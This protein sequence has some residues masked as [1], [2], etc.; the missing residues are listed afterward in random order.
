M[1]DEIKFIAGVLTGGEPHC[2][3]DFDWYYILGFLELHKIAGVFYRR[4]AKKNIKIPTVVLRKLQGIFKGQE[5]RVRMMRKWIEDVSYELDC[6]K[7]DYIFLKGSVLAHTVF[8]GAPAYSDG[9]RVSN[10]IDILVRS[11]CVTEVANALKNMGFKQGFWDWKTQKFNPLSRAE[12]VSRRMNRGETAPF[13]AL[14]ENER[15]PFIEVD[16]NFSVDYLPTGGERIV[17]AMLLSKK[18]YGGKTKRRLYGAS[19][20]WFFIHLILHQYKESVLYFM[21]ERGKETDL[22]KLLDIYL[23][24]KNGI[25][26]LETVK[27]IAVVYGLTGEVC[28]VLQSVQ[29]V[30]NCEIPEWAKAEQREPRVVMPA[31]NREFEWTAPLEER[32]SF[33]NRLSFLREVNR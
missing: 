3:A 14:T 13:I 20:E 30:F 6:A 1:R 21:A 17:D 29:K 9:E 27:N 22:Y 33:F 28:A 10:D 23:L 15:V 12:I 26:D 18:Q 25:I 24:M 4:A 8:C 2:A 5:Y 11:S 32:I 7:L 31:E 19:P 16:V